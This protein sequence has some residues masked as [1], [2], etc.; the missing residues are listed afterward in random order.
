MERDLPGVG[1]R[2]QGEASDEGRVEV[3]WEERALEPDLVGIVSAPVVG[4]DFLIRPGLPAT[5]S[6]APSAVPRW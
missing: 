2:E 6:V 3:G 1:V 4:Q 5:T